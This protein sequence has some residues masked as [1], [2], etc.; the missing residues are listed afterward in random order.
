MEKINLI[1]EEI[2]KPQELNFNIVD[3][4]T[5][6]AEDNDYIFLED[7]IINFLEEKIK[8]KKYTIEDLKVGYSFSY[9]Q[10]DGLNFEGI[11]T[12]DKIQVK[13]K[14]SSFHYEHSYTTNFD[15]IQ[16]KIKNKWAYYEDLTDKEKEKADI[17]LKDF[18]YFYHNL[19]K[20]AE[21]FGYKCI[22]DADEDNILRSGFKDFLNKNNIEEKELFD[23]EYTTQDPKNKQYIKV[24]DSGNTNIGLWI[25]FNKIKISS[26]VKATANIEEYNKVELI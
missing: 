15:V 4:D 16:V 9:S 6:N 21:H 3:L 25:K 5:K 2:K 14:H 26:F 18:E 10:G 20:E 13:L 19:C 23:F 12:T 1:K 17:F 8:N 24:C 7:E 22:E 11:L